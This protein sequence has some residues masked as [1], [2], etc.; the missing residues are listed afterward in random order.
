MASGRVFATVPRFQD[1][2][3]GVF[4]RESDS[5]GEMPRAI[6]P[7]PRERAPPHTTRCTGRRE[8]SSIGHAAR[9]RMH[10]VNGASVAHAKVTRITLPSCFTVRGKHHDTM[11]RSGGG[12]TPFSELRSSSV[13]PVKCW[14][15]RIRG[16]IE[17]SN[18]MTARVFQAPGR[19]SHAFVQSLMCG[20][21]PSG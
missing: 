8:V 11:V 19:Q 9:S 16:I 5:T 21:D 2:A 15:D 6:R 7:L 17:W 10:T 14:K 1:F 18:L 20:P 13:P 12:S 3:G 4:Q